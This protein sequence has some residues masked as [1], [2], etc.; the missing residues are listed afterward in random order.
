MPAKVPPIRLPRNEIC[1]GGGADDLVVAMTDGRDT[2]Q[3]FAV[4]I[5]AG[6]SIRREHDLGRL[7]AIISGI[8][9]VCLIGAAC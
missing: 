7:L 2:L 5:F 1:L 3:S 4:R 6:E 9:C 8:G